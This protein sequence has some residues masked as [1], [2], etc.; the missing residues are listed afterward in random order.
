[1]RAIRFHEL[2][3][4]EVLRLEDLP[5][6][7]AGPGEVVVAVHAAG[8]NYADTRRR[9]GM[10]LEESPL[11][12]VPGSEVAGMV[13]RVGAGVAGWQVGAQVMAMVGG[14]GYAEAAVVP[15]TNLIP[16]PDG[17]SYAEAAA[18]P[19][20]GL[21][22]YHAL[23][24]S[25]RLAPGEAV[26]VHSAAGGVGT[27]AV[28]LA[29]LMGAG[30]VF[31]TA[32]TLAKLELARSLGADVTINYTQE[33]FAARIRDYQRERGAFGVDVVLEAVGGE[34]LERSLACLNAF[35]RLVIFGAASGQITP[36]APARLM[37][38]CQEII[39]FYLPVL[40]TRPELI[41]AG[42]RALSEYLAAGQLRIIVGATYPLE[43]AAEAHRALEARET[44]GKVVLQVRDTGA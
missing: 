19:V 36:V 29:R 38:R 37:R 3:E 15:A 34:V 22:A 10:Y 5:E 26:L 8:I 6:P 31:A 40:L 43:A 7:Q 18:F 2:G 21:T 39:G 41:L 11:P 23:R 24:T 20:Q 4:P 30:T 28:Q 1:M 25:G 13:A 35:G 9:R 16:I 12:F 33:D 44:S 17:M 14:G 27:L 32:S 42:V